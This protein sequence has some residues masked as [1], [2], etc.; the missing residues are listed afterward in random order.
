M[1]IL[2][3]LP[4][5]FVGCTF[6]IGS[7]TIN[8]FNVTKKKPNNFYYT[9]NLAKNLTLE[10]SFKINLL[11]TNFYKEKE[12]SKEDIDTVKKFTKA[13]K[14]PNFI[15]K[16]KDLPEKPAYKLFFTFSKEKYVV[17]VYDEKY[18][19]VQP[20]DG[21]YSMDYIDMEGIQPLYNLF[22]LC[23]YIIPKQ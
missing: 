10:S 6:K 16:P 17:N 15:E 8:N 1:V 23:N 4:V 20:W 18:L 13:L 21:N 19:S 11:D 12:L 7:Y 2:I 5:I 22:G 3:L 14:K 9:N